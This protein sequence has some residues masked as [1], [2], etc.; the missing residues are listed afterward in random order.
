MNDVLSNSAVDMN[1]AMSRNKALDAL[2]NGVAS[3]LPA[4]RGRIAKPSTGS[5]GY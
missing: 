1:T 4:R 2:E 5:C 3:T